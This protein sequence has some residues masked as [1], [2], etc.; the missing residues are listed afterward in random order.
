MRI[1]LLT[2]GAGGSFYCEN[3]VRDL[4]LVRAQRALGHD[5]FMVPL[6]LPVPSVTASERAG[7]RVFFGGVNVYLQQRWVLFR[8]TP[9]WVDRLFDAR[10]LLEWAARRAGTTR[11]VDL[12]ATTI[13]ML[14]GEHG[15]Q[16]KELARLVDWLGS[17]ERPDIVFLSNALLIGA[18]HRLRETLRLPVACGLQGE[19]VFLD[20]LREADRGLAWRT[21]REHAGEVDLFVAASRFYR[22][23]MI[24]RLGLAPERVRVVPNG[25]ALDDDDGRAR[26]REPVIGYLSRMCRGGGLDILAEALILM[27]RGGKVRNFRLRA[28]GGKTADDDDFVAAVRARLDANGLGGR[29]EIL[30]N[31]SGESKRAFLRSLSVLSVPSTFGEAFGLFVLEALATG[32]PVVQPR[33]GAFSELIEA[34]GGGLLCAPADPASLAQCLEK[35]LLDPALAQ[36]LGERGRQNVR[37][38]F[39]VEKT[40]Q[41]LIDVFAETVA[42]S[43]APSML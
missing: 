4:D 31:L 37:A 20:E 15:R 23:F 32:V 12:G 41:A 17:V 43:K 9:R 1:A 6:Y 35:L 42:R 28:A 2:P 19:H 34:T 27:E 21:L 18:A 24:E 29:F 13:S 3:C 7:S 11:A 10:W 16:A 30:P 33:S 22:D 25:V 8:R 14:R 38:H 39:A 26:S 40:A 36:E 5:A